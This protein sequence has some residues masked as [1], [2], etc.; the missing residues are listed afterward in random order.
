MEPVAIFWTKKA[1][2]VYLF[3]FLLQEDTYVGN[4]QKEGL[5]IPGHQG[6][7]FWEGSCLMCRRQN[8]ILTL[9][10]EATGDREQHTVSPLLLQGTLCSPFPK[11]EKYEIVLQEQDSRGLEAQKFTPWE[12]LGMLTTQDLK[13]SS[14]LMSYRIHVEVNVTL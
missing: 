13:E 9:Q 7:C 12:L 11:S 5:G 6:A 10:K 1:L 3:V 4:P 8:V 2:S 14:V